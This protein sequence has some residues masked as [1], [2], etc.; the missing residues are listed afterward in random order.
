MYKTIIK[1]TATFVKT[2]TILF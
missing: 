2:K 1:N